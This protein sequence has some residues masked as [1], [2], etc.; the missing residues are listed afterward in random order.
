MPWDKAFLTQLLKVRS[1]STVSVLSF[2]PC[3]HFILVSALSTSTAPASPLTPCPPTPNASNL[4]LRLPLS[5]NFQHPHI[6]LSFVTSAW[7]ASGI[8]PIR[9]HASTCFSSGQNRHACSAALAR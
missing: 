2:F 9:R 5:V 6:A 4:A 3:L 7:H 1:S 8:K